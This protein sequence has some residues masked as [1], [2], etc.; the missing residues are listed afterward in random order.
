MIGLLVLSASCV[1]VKEDDF[2]VPVRDR[3]YS[4]TTHADDQQRVFHIDLR[5]TSNEPICIA[6]LDWPREDGVWVGPA[7]LF[8]LRSR[9][10]ERT[11]R[12]QNA[13]SCAGP[14]CIM[15]IEAGESLSGALRYSVFGDPDEIAALHDKNLEYGLVPSPC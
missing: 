6:G 5:S 13:G 12:D 14:N 11:T 15:R 8:I 10:G 7:N 9:E 3:D 4:L 2:E 1:A